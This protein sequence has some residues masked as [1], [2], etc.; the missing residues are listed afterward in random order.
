MWLITDRGFYSAVA[1]RTKPETIIVRARD[2]RD[3]LRLDDLIPDGTPSAAERIWE[4]PRA[5]YRYRM[6]VSRTEWAYACGQLAVG[7]DYPNFKDAVTRTLG[8]ARHDVYM[9]VWSVLQNIA[10]RGKGGAYASHA[11]P[12]GLPARSRRG[13][14]TGRMRA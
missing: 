14:G 4:D 2:R 13:G 11:E 5:D 6:E 10:P 8:R 9:R 12:L 3:L 7:I 1:H